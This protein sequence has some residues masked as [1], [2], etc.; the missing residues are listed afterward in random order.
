MRQAHGP[1]VGT[2]EGQGVGLLLTGQQEKLLELLTEER[3]PRRVIKTQG[4]QGIDHP[5][6]AG[7][8]A[9]EGLHANDRDDHLGGHAIF[10]LG[11]RQCLGVLLPEHHAAGNSRVG[12]KDRP[13][14]FPRFDLL[15]RARDGI[16]DRLLA[17]DLG[18]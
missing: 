7:I 1:G 16:E 2:L 15:G 17:L 5:I 11:A 14:V 12:D 9:V 10:L 4:R 6:V 18:K 8:A 3:R 13:V